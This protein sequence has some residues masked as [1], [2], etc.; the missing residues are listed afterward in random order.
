MLAQ[1]SARRKA[2]LSSLQSARVALFS[3]SSATWPGE[4]PGES[5]DQ[6][7]RS[8]TGDIIDTVESAVST[9]LGC[10]GDMCTSPPP[11]DSSHGLMYN[12]ALVPAGVDTCDSGDV[13]VPND[14]LGT[15]GALE[16]AVGEALLAGVVI[17]AK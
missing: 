1:I 13:D 3:A 11:V 16:D 4:R 14:G 5:D 15:L 9:V 10:S 7:D 12:A 6:S 8:A 2:F 17:P